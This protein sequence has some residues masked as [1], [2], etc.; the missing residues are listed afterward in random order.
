MKN[1]LNWCTVPANGDASSRGDPHVTTFNNISYDFQGAGEFVHLMD[2]SGL[3]IQVRQ[4]PVSSAGGIP[5][6]AHTGLASCVSIIT[7]VAARV[8]KHRVT[9][10]PGYDRERK[11]L[12]LR[13]DGKERP[14]SREGISLGGGGRVISATSGAPGDIE[15]LF[16]D[17]T[18]LM[19]TT[20]W[21]PS[22]KI[23]YMN[24]EVINTHA[25]EGIMGAI[26]AG[27]W[28]PTLPDGTPMGLLPVSLNQRYFDLNQTFADAWRVTNTTSLFDYAP[29]TSTATFTDKT[30]PPNKP[31]CVAPGSSTPQK[32]IDRE[33]ALGI[34]RKIKNETMRAQCIFDVSV[35]GEP[36][37]GRTYLKTQALV[38]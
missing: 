26:T 32:P 20:N 28:L 38:P 8:G 21:W 33:K 24:V 29:G 31:P 4:T 12:V 35:T 13:I 27:N 22:Q 17:G 36:G 34:C 9:L 6:D 1:L 18:R 37:F 3:E 23:W 5:P 14:I 25:R 19:I 10:E 16:S 2:A 30:W 15:I 7:A 11:A